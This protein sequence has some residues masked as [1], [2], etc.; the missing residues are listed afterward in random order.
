MEIED[1]KKE[2]VMVNYK[3][4]VCDNGMMKHHRN[5]T[6]L[7]DGRVAFLNVCSACG[8]EK[9]MSCFYPTVKE[10]KDLGNLDIQ[11][12]IVQLCSKECDAHGY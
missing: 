6:K 8:T 1:D 10:R 2:L 5:K 3:C 7:I 12:C 4:D 9:Y 11:G